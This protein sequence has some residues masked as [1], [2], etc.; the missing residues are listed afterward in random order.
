MEGYAP[1]LDGSGRHGDVLAYERLCK[2]NGKKAVWYGFW[3]G[4]AVLTVLFFLDVKLMVAGLNIF[5][6]DG[7][8]V[9]LWLFVRL[10]RWVAHSN[11]VKRKL[12]AVVV[13]LGSLLG[14][15][16]LVVFGGAFWGVLDFYEQ[17]TEPQTGRT[18]AVEYRQNMMGRGRV[19]LYERFGLLLLACDVEEY[20]G[21]FGWEKPARAYLSK[22]G[23]IIVVEFFFLNPIFCVPA[24]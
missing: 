1:G 23:Q 8:A 14:V 10:T 20:V 13:I 22:D 18:F 5:W 6:W 21:E 11:T 4:M 7:L 24:A 15:M 17:V 3:A 9:G 16:L 2:M 12:A 19:K